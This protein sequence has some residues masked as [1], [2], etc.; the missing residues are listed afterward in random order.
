MFDE[1]AHE[2]ESRDPDHQKQ[3]V[4]LTDG[5][6]ALKIRVHRYLDGFTLVLDLMHVLL[7]LWKV[8][9][10]FHKE[11]S[12]EAIRWVKERT[13]RIL[14]GK[15]VDVARGARIAATKQGL[16]GSRRKTVLGPSKIVSMSCRSR[17]QWT[18]LKSPSVQHGR[19]SPG[20][21]CAP[22][23]PPRFS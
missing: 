10:A 18:T 14:E 5:E 15:V 6:L 19:V 9:H 7:R 17:N 23:R 13:Q 22:Y 20:L 2:C 11:G 8:A 21:P 1:I 12:P 3:R 16:K 4:A